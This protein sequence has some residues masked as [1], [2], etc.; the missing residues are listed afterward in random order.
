MNS[1]ELWDEADKVLPP[2]N[3]PCET[4]VRFLD[5]SLDGPH[6]TLA[7]LRRGELTEKGGDEYVWVNGDDIQAIVAGE[8][9]GVKMCGV[10]YWRL[11]K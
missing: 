10:K 6:P 2:L 9:P 8:E 3:T 4:L 5:G 7:V 11:A 1:D